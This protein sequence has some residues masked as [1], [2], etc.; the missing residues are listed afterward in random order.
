MRWRLETLDTPSHIPWVLF[1]QQIIHPGVNRAGAIKDRLRF[2]STIRLPYVFHMQHR[3][4]Y[5]LSIPKRDFTAPWFQ[6]FSERFGD[7]KRERHRPEN[8]ARKLHVVTDAF[9]I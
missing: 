6:R 3:E 8:T 5:S 1:V 9:V 2:G 4:H 7:I